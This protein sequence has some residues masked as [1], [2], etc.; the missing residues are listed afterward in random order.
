[1]EESNLSPPV[2][3][4]VSR[5]VYADPPAH[6]GSLGVENGGSLTAGHDPRAP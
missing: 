6:T 5:E 2:L 1:M 4:T 3:A